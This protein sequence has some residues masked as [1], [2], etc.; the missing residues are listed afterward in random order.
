MFIKNNFEFEFYV[1]LNIILIY[2]FRY[3]CDNSSTLEE[4]MVNIKKCFFGRYCLVGLI[5]ESDVIDCFVGR[6]CFEGE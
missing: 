1:D 3:Y 4:V 2:L 5:K 6:Y